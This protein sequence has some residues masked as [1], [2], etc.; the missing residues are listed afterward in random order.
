MKWK[1]FR[2]IGLS[3]LQDTIATN[4]LL[5]SD[6]TS[7]SRI[8]PAENANTSHLIAGINFKLLNSLQS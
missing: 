1:T 2:N 7:A 4:L 5:L 8:S 3:E 6:I